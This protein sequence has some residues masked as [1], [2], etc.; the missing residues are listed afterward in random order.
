M[1]GALPIR[2]FLCLHPDFA[3]H[4]VSVLYHAAVC[5]GRG[6]AALHDAFI[7]VLISTL[8]F[9]WIVWRKN[10]KILRY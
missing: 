3:S 2:Q 5:A 4:R 10:W 8:L 9:R 7:S 6:P 1:R